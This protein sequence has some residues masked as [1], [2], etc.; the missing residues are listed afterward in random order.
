MIASENSDR[1][2]LLADL[3]GLRRPIA[4][5]LSQLRGFPWDSPE[6]LVTLTRA[7]LSNLLRAYLKGVL[8]AAECERWAE[9]VSGRDDVALDEDSSGLLGRILFEM[10]SPELFEPISVQVARGW[11]DRLGSV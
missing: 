7:D 9:A 4:E 8:E 1:A 6:E 3:I 11:L 10:S 5:S 2:S